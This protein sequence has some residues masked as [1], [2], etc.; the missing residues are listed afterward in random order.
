MMGQ[1][2]DMSHSDT[3]ANL[4]LFAEEVLPRLQAL[5]QPDPEQTAA[6]AASREAARA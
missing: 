3:E 5:P 6:E 4:T 2:G 1:A